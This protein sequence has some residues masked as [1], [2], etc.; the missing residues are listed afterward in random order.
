MI[1]SFKHVLESGNWADME[2]MF[3]RTREGV[4]IPACLW[5]LLHRSFVG[6]KSTQCSFLIDCGKVLM[7]VP[8]IRQL[9]AICKLLI[10]AMD[11]CLLKF[12]F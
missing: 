2:H 9:W 10:L 6:T 7:G 11:F 3:V 8:G 5:L 1:G 12:D 4:V